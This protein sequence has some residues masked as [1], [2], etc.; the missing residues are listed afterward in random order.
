[1]PETEVHL[2]D[3]SG[4]CLDDAPKNS[5]EVQGYKE[6]NT[7][8]ILGEDQTGSNA[9]EVLDLKFDCDVGT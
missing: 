6:G 3:N 2:S 1:M 7:C 5:Y 8:V 4:K 9:G